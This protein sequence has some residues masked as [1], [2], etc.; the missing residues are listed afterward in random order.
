MSRMITVGLVVYLLMMG[1]AAW[2]APGLIAH[3]PTARALGE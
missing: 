2:V 1:A 3:A